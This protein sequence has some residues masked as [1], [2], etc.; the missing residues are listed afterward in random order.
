MNSRPDAPTLAVLQWRFAA[1]LRVSGAETA[2]AVAGLADSVVADGLAPASRIQVYRNNGRAMFEG[3]LGRTYPVL[4]RRVG[5][6]SF[7]GLARAYRAAHP[8]RSG[9][10]HWVG[11]DFPSW[12][13]R[14]LAGTEYAWLGDLARLEWACEEALVGERRP[15]LDRSTLAQVAPESLGD[16]GLVLQPNLRTIHS[17]H[18]IW[19]VWRENQPDSPGAPVDFAIGAQHVVVTCSDEGL[20]LHSLAADR[21]AFVDALA[22]GASLASA[23]DASGLAVG[24]LPGMLAWLF[25]EE[26][27]VDLREP[28]SAA[29]SGCEP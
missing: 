1:A 14:H 25:G 24:A 10:L 3:A 7:S 22:A 9:D 2:A 29:A 17:G 11:R 13:A 8:S 18:P 26:L 28:R 23:L 5:E 20:A 21:C 16:V 12:V 15:A 27:V 4:R 6:A 19:S